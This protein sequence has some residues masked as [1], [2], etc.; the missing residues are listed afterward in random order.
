MQRIRRILVVVD[1]VRDEQPG[2]EV[3]L[4][5]A[6]A[7]GASLDLFA[8]EF[9][10]AQIRY[11]P[12]EIATT[13]HFH[14]LI[15]AN[16]ERKLEALAGRARAAGVEAHTQTVWAA[17]LHEQIGVRAEAVHAD[18]VVKSTDYHSR[19][20][21]TLFSGTDWN[22]IRDCPMPLLLAKKAPWPSSPVVVAALDPLHAHDK[23]AV[24]D[25]Q[26]IES[27]QLIAKMLNGS[28]AAL[29]V[30]ALPGALE[31][32]G[33]AAAAATLTTAP[34][35][36]SP[37][38]EEIAGSLAQLLEPY[39]VPPDRQHVETGRPADG[40]VAFATDRNA[41]LV[42]M[43]AVSRS[44]LER[45]FVGSTAESVLDRLPCN[46]LVEKPA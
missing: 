12:V 17:P 11:H 38:L 9:R 19:I 44:R 40:I 31:A 23:P 3:A 8:C 45:F 34:L 29:H 26:L 41:D 7:A 4:P 13:Q 28:V 42:V 39:G 18:L 24:L 1:P 27:A 43:G 36:E 16:L 2:F 33:D 5:V 37:S 35:P 10:D 6:R 20:R 15:I 30:H 32:M 14:D 25:R 22:L 46:V 21:R